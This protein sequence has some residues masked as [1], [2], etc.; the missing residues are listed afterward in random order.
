MNS[1]ATT[2][3][4][5]KYLLELGLKS[6]TADLCYRFRPEFG[7]YFFVLGHAVEEDDIPS[8]SLRALLELLPSAI[9]LNGHCYSLEIGK[10]ANE[11]EWYVSY[12]WVGWT[13]KIMKGN[14]KDDAIFDM[15]VW[16][17]KDKHIK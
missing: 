9:E 10:L 13:Y 8:W 12:E 15:I 4:Q 7:E 11:V 2:I 3:E 17:L 14:L 6:N 16:L 1:I 5:S